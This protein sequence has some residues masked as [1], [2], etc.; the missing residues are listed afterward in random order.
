MLTQAMSNLLPGFR[1][2]LEFIRNNPTLPNLIVRGGGGVI[3]QGGLVFY[4]KSIDW[5]GDNK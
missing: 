1:V 4:Y 5:E 3:K 2:A